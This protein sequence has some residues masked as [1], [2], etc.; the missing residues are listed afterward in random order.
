M[1]I[2]FPYLS[3]SMKNFPYLSFNETWTLRVLF[4]A[5]LF[6]PAFYWH[7]YSSNFPSSK[8]QRHS[9]FSRCSANLVTTDFPLSRQNSLWIPHS[10]LDPLPPIWCM[11]L[12]VEVEVGRAVERPFIM[13]S[14]LQFNDHSAVFYSSTTLPCHAIS[15]LKTFDAFFTYNMKTTC[16]TTFLTKIWSCCQPLTTR[17]LIIHTFSPSCLH[18]TI[19]FVSSI[20]LPFPTNVPL[21][22]IPSAAAVATFVYPFHQISC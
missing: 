20:P 3:V 19:L 5:C 11:S 13:S 8:H 9:R 18:F 17:Y 22:T 4:L 10:Y 21:L 15:L 6:F 14:Q 2:G 1:Q 7:Y 16:I 12:Q